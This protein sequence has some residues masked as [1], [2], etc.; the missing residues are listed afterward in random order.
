M[1]QQ[2]LPDGSI[3]TA[4]NPNINP[5][6]TAE[7]KNSGI[8][9]WHGTSLDC[10][11]TLTGHVGCNGGYTYVHISVFAD[12]RM[13]SVTDD[14][15]VRVWTKVLDDTPSAQLVAHR[16]S[17]NQTG[18][19]HGIQQSSDAAMPFKGEPIIHRKYTGDSPLHEQTFNCHPQALKVPS[20]SSPSV[21]EGKEKCEY[22]IQQCV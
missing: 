8:S 15:Q 11:Y 9:I 22:K 3:V 13:V 12:G 2:L 5:N 6:A 20:T 1:A 4:S 16:E 7:V 10:I 19:F 21:S 14:N 17:T 18:A